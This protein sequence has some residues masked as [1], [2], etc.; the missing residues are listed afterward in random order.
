MEADKYIPGNVL[1]AASHQLQTTNGNSSSV[2]IGKLGDNFDRQSYQ[3]GGEDTAK[4]DVIAGF[5]QL[6]PSM[7]LASDRGHH[8]LRTI[9]RITRETEVFSGTC[10]KEG[11]T[12][13]LKPLFRSPWGL[14][15]DERG[16]QKI[17]VSDYGNNAIR[18]INRKSGYCET[19]SASSVLNGPRSLSFDWSGQNLVIANGAG[20]F[21]SHLNLD[22]NVH[23]VIIGVPGT[24]GYREESTTTSLLNSPSHIISISET[25]QLIADDENHR[26]RIVDLKNKELYTICSGIEENRNGYV[27]DCRI[28]NPLSLLYLDDYLYIGRRNGISRMRGTCIC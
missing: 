11:F 24:A 15:L 22:S 12:D 19:I 28:Q 26:V 16:L 10:T 7:V 8:C 13:G 17:Y 21:I 14:I 5:V 23:E 4:F 25:L 9:N 18:V 20:E 1:Y 3:P 6:S 2:I 27:S